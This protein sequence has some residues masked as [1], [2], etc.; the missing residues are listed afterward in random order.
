MVDFTSS[1]LFMYTKL[2]THTIFRSD[3]RFL[4]NKVIANITPFVTMLKFTL[5]IY[6]KLFL[7][8]CIVGMRCEC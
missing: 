4:P 6:C 1:L 3:L 7:G 5:V 8:V 2:D